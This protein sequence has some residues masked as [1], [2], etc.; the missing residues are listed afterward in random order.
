MK[1]VPLAVL[2]VAVAAQAQT[3]MVP[4]VSGT[5]CAQR[6]IERRPVELGLISHE[7]TGYYNGRVCFVIYTDSSARFSMQQDE[8][9]PKMLESWMLER[10]PTT[11][12]GTMWGAH[13][14]DFDEDANQGIEQYIIANP[15]PGHPGSYKV[16]TNIVF[17]GTGQAYV[18][19][20]WVDA[21]GQ[22]LNMGGPTLKP[23]K[24]PIKQQPQS[25]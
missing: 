15:I 8:A 1:A 9:S 24:L 19:E 20:F 5:L 13:S 17:R 3:V 22:L 23:A 10:G 18:A 21:N 14:R 12:N 7:A 25:L 2:L 16:T 4:H 11:D 6:R